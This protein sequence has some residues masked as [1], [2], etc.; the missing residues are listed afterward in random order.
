MNGYLCQ[1]NRLLLFFLFV[2]FASS[3]QNVEAEYD[4]NHDFSH[5]K[6]FRMGESEIITPK[7]QVQPNEVSLQKIV[8]DEIIEEL[9]EKG[10]QQVDSAADLVVSFVAGSQQRHDMGNVG[11]LGLTPGSTSQTWQRDFT[12]ESLIIDLNDKN[13]NLVWR[14]NAST[15]ASASDMKSLV[16]SIVAAGFKK[17]SLK[18]KKVKKK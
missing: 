15:T 1:M 3:A 11:P 9:K 16:D 5:Y 2:S 18:P 14:V 10:L 7:D 12:M 17:F 6:T 13:N 8:Q 4:K